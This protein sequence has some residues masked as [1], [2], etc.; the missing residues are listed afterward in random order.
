VDSKSN[1]CGL[2]MSEPWF[3]FALQQTET[4][5]VNFCI[6]LAAARDDEAEIRR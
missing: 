6:V 4:R 2:N 5:T 1:W 3:F